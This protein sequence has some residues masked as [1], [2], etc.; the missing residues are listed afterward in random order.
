MVMALECN[1]SAV[2]PTAVIVDDHAGLRVM[3][4]QVLEDAGFDV[5]GEAEDGV[6]A[7]STVAAL[8]PR[9]VLADIQLPETDGFAVAARLA[10]TTP[11]AFVVLTSVR[12]AVEFGDRLTGS[13]AQRFIPKAELSGPDLLAMVAGTA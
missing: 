1:D 12:S 13:A 11:D 5:V 9:L 10:R 8:R 6:G 3:A 2:T 4:C 7:L